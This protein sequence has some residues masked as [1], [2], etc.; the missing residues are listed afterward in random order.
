MLRRSP[1]SRACI[2]EQRSQGK[3]GKQA[4]TF[5]RDRYG[6]RLGN[7]GRKL[8]ILP[9]EAK[10]LSVSEFTQ[11]KVRANTPNKFG[12]TNEQLILPSGGSATGRGVMTG[13]F[14]LWYLLPLLL[15]VPQVQKMFKQ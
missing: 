9:Q 14:K 6:S 3:T 5:C 12:M 15:F 4:R 1:E 11:Q 8:G 10:G 7:A 13:G 2:D